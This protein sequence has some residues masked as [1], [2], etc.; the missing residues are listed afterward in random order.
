MH[1]NMSL[2]SVDP[3]VDRALGTFVDV[4]AHSIPAKISEIKEQ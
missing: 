2:A 1:Q 4:A 3:I